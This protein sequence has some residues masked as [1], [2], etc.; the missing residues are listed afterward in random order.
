MTLDPSNC[1]IT[2][3]TTRTENW[4]HL[5]HSFTS[6]RRRR[7]GREAVR[8]ENKNQWRKE[9]KTGLV[10]R[11]EA[12]G[13]GKHRCRGEKKSI[14]LCFVFAKIVL[15]A[16]KQ[17]CKIS[18]QVWESKIIFTGLYISV[19]YLLAI[20]A[21]VLV[22]ARNLRSVRNLCSRQAFAECL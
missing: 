6:C 8:N 18:F 16:R 20:R 9:R 14:V 4:S 3:A 7:T 19:L 17:D 12:G 5:L 13:R 22:K 10:E 21:A 11:G 15:T 2:V 1:I